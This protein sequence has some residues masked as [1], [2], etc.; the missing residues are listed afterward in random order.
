MGVF[1]YIIIQAGGK[2]KRMNNL[3]Y[4]KPK[5]LIP[6]NNKPILFYIFEKFKEAKFIIITDYKKEVLKDYLKI[7]ANNYNYE[8]IEAPG[9]GTLAGIKTALNKIPS[10]QSFLIIWSDLILKKE[11][12]I[13]KLNFGKN[14]VGLSTNFTCRWHFKNNKF[15]EKRS[16]KYGVAGFFIFSNKK[17]LTDIP[18]EGEFVKYLK[19]SKI[20]FLPLVLEGVDEVGTFEK[21]QKIT[22]YSS[23]IR[24]FNKIKIFNKYVEKIPIDEKGENLNKLEVNF[25]KKIAKKNFDFFPKIFKFNPLTIKKIHGKPFFYYKDFNY[26][27]KKKLL[28]KVV[29]QL[30]TLHNSFKPITANKENDN[31]AIIEKTIKRVKEV[32]S[33]IP[34]IKE[35]FFIINKLKCFN[36]I[37]K[38][39]IIEEEMEKFYP[40]IYKPIHGDPT[41]S[42]M[43]YERRIKKIYFIDPRGYYGKIKFYGDVDYDWAKIYYSLV[44]NYDQFN[45]KKFELKINKNVI[46]ITINSNGWEKLEGYYFELIKSNI[47]KI[48]FFHGIIWLSLTTYVW[49]NYDSILGAFYNGIYYLQK[50]YDAKKSS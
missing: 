24:P 18:Q 48:K 7:Y 16:K 32:S 36:F 1:K 21:Y 5:C 30:I 43:L 26:S 11:F 39:S 4:N 15:N 8:I 9:K 40:K 27:F 33:L 34:N 14:Y 17:Y 12:K 31:E 50:Y 42:N 23:P 28:K 2:G 41:F 13:P 44:G 3:T 47:D 49:D 35:D 25:Y 20:E 45:L 22:K 6:I 10:N 19:Y 29:E 38:L 37:K 46:K